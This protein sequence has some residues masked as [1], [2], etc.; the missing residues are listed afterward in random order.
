MLKKEGLRGKEMTT[1]EPFERGHAVLAGIFKGIVNDD[2]K[3]K[4]DK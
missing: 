3:E 1:L 4:E 2:E